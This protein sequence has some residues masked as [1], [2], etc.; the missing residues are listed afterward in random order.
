MAKSIQPSELSL[1]D[2][3]P[4]LDYQSVD[5]EEAVLGA[6]QSAAIRSKRPLVLVSAPNSLAMSPRILNKSGNLIVDA[7]IG[8]FVVDVTC[9]CRIRGLGRKTWPCMRACGR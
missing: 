9:G 4:Y 8:G 2:M 1:H 6:P 5:P 7:S 3:G